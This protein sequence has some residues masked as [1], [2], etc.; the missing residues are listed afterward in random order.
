MGILANHVPSIEPLRPGVVEVV[1]AAGGSTKWFGESP[2][3]QPFIHPDN[4]CTQFRVDLPPCIPTTSLPLTLW[5]LHGL[6][7]FPQRQVSPF[8]VDCFYLIHRTLGN[9]HEPA[10]G[11]TARCGEWLGRGKD[12]SADRSRCLRGLATCRCLEII[13][14]HYDRILYD[15]VDAAI[16]PNMDVRRHSRNI[17]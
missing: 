4:R 8:L 13:F 3:C 14:C 1:E 15:V 17:A 6:K 2:S 10:R 12:G 11:I 9:S 7:I 16:E 5:R